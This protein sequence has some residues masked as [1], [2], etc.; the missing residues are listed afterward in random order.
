MTTRE[1]AVLLP[2]GWAFGSTSSL[3]E[4]H[5]PMDPVSKRKP[6]TTNQDYSGR[7]KEFWGSNFNLKRNGGNTQVNLG[8]PSSELLKP[9]GWLEGMQLKE[10]SPFANYA[11]ETRTRE[12]TLSFT[13]SQA[14]SAVLVIV[15]RS[16]ADSSPLP[17]LYQDLEPW[18]QQGPLVPVHILSESRW[19]DS[20]PSTVFPEPSQI[21]RLFMP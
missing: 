5:L 2:L 1:K 6:P 21:L 17:D 18:C 12:K 19:L 16:R 11:P 14:Q 3:R 8:T 20:N 9:Q 4:P 10:Q 13:S 7:K 15:K